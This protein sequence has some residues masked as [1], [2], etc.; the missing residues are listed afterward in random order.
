MTS[1]LELL[2]RARSLRAVAVMYAVPESSDWNVDGAL[3]RAP[4]ATLRGVAVCRWP[5]R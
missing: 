5:E 3:D 1:L 4:A 2:N